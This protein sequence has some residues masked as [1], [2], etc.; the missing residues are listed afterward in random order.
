ME[1][2]EARTAA[3]LAAAL[4]LR[5]RVFMDEQGVSREEELDGRDDEAVHVVALEGDEVVG[6]C[7]LLIDGDSAKL[8][9]MAVAR[10]SRRRGV[11][12]ALLAESE[13]LSRG[14]G[15]RRIAL[16]AQ[17]HAMGLYE[18]A[19]YAARGATFMDAGIEHVTMERG[20]AQAAPEDERDQISTEHERA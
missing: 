4:A 17:T 11:G 7:R 9:R 12:A 15:A 5:A 10:E 19:G 18:A 20:L 3:E 6:T 2:R 1:V 13:A 14:R 16:D 8:G